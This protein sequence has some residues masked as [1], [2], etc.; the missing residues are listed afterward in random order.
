MLGCSENRDP[1]CSG[2]PGTVLVSWVLENS[3]P[4]FQQIRLGGQQIFWGFPKH[5]NALLAMRRKIFWPP[6]SGR[7]MHRSGAAIK[8]PVTGRN[9]RRR[10]RCIDWWLQSVDCRIGRGS[11]IDWWLQSVDCD[12]E[13]WGMVMCREISQWT[14]CLNL[15]TILFII[16]FLAPVF[17]NFAP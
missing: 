5:K 3:V 6:H 10:G 14:K 2:I 7:N 8:K 17:H 11:C 15:I 16:S 4:V 9:R 1:V 12:C 13:G